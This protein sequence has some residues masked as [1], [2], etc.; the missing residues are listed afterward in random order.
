MCLI[1]PQTGSQ[2]VARTVCVGE[3]HDNQVGALLKGVP[4][5]AVV[6]MAI[7]G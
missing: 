5:G 7:T 1:S 3:G 4:N 6:A 2:E